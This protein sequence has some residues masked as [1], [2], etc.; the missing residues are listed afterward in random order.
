MDGGAHGGGRGAKASLRPLGCERERRRPAPAGFPL[1]RQ[2]HC[3]LRT[4][5]MRCTWMS[6][7]CSSLRGDKGSS[8][9][10]PCLCTKARGR[11]SSPARASEG[12][13]RGLGGRSWGA[14][15]CSKAGG[16][17]SSPGSTEGPVREGTSWECFLG[18]HITRKGGLWLQAQKATGAER[19]GTA[20]GAQ[21]LGHSGPRGSPTVTHTRSQLRVRSRISFTR[22][23][24]KP[25]LGG[26]EGRRGA[27]PAASPH[28]PQAPRGQHS[29]GQP[30]DNMSLAQPPGPWSLTVA[31][32]H[33]LPCPTASPR[34][35]T[36]EMQHF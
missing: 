25:R 27:H 26:R 17:C 5:R 18:V 12:V 36:A 23:V 30:Q 10:Q 14:H 2:V 21:V 1:R 20:P 29:G 9:A 31:S 3:M 8:D 35:P 13:L 28:G 7:H 11:R 33:G 6:R 34:F 15:G 22:H 16:S 19:G 24:R 32:R 4:W